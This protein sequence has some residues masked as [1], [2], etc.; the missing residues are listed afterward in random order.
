MGVSIQRVAREDKGIPRG[1]IATADHI[2]GKIIHRVEE[3][4]G[5]VEGGIEY[6]IRKY[7]DPPKEDGC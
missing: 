6:L 1:E 2:V 3:V 4:D 7:E 5:I